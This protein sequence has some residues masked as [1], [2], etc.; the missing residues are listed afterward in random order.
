MS[1]SYRKIQQSYFCM[2]F[3][4][5]VAIISSCL[6]AQYFKFSQD[7]QRTCAATLRRVHETIV[8][9]ESNNYYTFCVCVCACVH[10]WV[11]VCVC[12]CGCVPACK[13]TYAVHHEQA[14]YCLRPLWLHH[15]SRRYLSLT[16]RFLKK[17]KSC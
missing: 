16:A 5:I 9:A 10:A 1:L 7:R 12:V 2:I 4:I 11:R 6:F 15:I 17:I 3:T 14:P 13:L 8:A